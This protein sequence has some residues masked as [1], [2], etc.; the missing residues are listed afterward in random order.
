MGPGGEEGRRGEGRFGIISP[1]GESGE[2]ASERAKAMLNYG[3]ILSYIITLK[4]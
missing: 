3:L 4:Q 1:E 2:E